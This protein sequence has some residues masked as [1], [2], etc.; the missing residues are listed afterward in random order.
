MFIV[1]LLK[2]SPTH[3]HTYTHTLTY[4]FIHFYIL[5]ISHKLC[6]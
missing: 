1:E 2:D 3:T 5:V 4:M 6:S